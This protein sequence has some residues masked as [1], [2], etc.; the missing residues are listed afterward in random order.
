VYR[1]IDPTAAQELPLRMLFQPTG[2][3]TFY[4]ACEADSP[5]A[6]VA[7]LLGDPG[8]VELPLADRLQQRMRLASDICLLLDLD[9]EHWELGD[10]DAARTINV[11]SDLEFLRSAE[12]AGFVS[13]AFNLEEPG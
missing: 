6:L 4:R 1:L 3:G 11:H 5:R 2:G 10:R 8:Y 13:L 12:R 9:G 7:A